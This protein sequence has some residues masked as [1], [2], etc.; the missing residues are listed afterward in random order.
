MRTESET[1]VASATGSVRLAGQEDRDIEN[2]FLDRVAHGSGAAERIEAL[3]RRRP[4]M[5]RDRP[6]RSHFGVAGRREHRR[7]LKSRWRCT[8]LDPLGGAAPVVAQP[9]G[10]V[11]Q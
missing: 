1:R 6:C 5:F 10:K 11:R 4:R 2:L 9:A 8:A 7:I 3:W